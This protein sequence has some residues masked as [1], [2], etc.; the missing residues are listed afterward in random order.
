LFGRISD[1]KGKESIKLFGGLKGKIKNIVN[2][3]F[4]IRR[5]FRKISKPQWNGEQIIKRILTI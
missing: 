5:Q 2:L 4:T 1:R 3:D